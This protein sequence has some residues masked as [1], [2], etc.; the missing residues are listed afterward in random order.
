MLPELDM[1]ARYLVFFDAKMVSVQNTCHE[2][3]KSSSGGIYRD[4]VCSCG[5]CKPP[6]VVRVV[7]ANII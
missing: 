1:K 3:H 4:G 6:V 7:S 5:N 2:K